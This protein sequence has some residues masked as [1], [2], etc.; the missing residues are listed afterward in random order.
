MN[1]SEESRMPNAPFRSTDRRES[2]SSTADP[3]VIRHSRKSSL[4]SEA[5]I[6]GVRTTVCGSACTTLTVSSPIGRATRSAVNR[7]R[8]RPQSTSISQ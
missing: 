5:I 8:E 1:G 2:C 7:S 3:R 4:G 6:A